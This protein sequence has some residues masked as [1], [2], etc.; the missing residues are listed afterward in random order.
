MTPLSTT[1]GE[2]LPD[3]MDF[4]PRT[5]REGELD[6]SPDF[7]KLTPDTT[8]SRREKALFLAVF[9]IGESV[10][11]TFVTE[12]VKFLRVVVP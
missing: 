12:P 5:S 1:R 11:F 2:V 4:C 9:I 10:I 8:P 3:E 7:P 6:A